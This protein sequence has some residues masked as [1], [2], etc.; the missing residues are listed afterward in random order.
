MG[1]GRSNGNISDVGESWV[2]GD[3]VKLLLTV[4]ESVAQSVVMKE[5]K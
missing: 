4:L 2:E 5:K 1:P 3:L